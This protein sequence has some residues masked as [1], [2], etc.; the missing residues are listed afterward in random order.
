MA[1]MLHTNA[2]GHWPFGSGEEDFLKDFYHIWAWWPSWSCDPDALNKLSFPRTM[3][4]LHEIWLP[5]AQRFWR[6]SSKMVEE[7]TK[8]NGWT[9]EHAYTISSPMS[10][11]AQVS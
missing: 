7:Q 1:L 8:D 5:L 10:L 4:A 2:Q 3:E 11:N 9:M 6:R